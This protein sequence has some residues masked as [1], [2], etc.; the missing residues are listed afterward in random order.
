MTLPLTRSLSASVAAAGRELLIT[1]EKLSASY[2]IESRQGKA[3]PLHASSTFASWLTRSSSSAAAHTP[4]LAASPAAGTPTTSPSG[5]P[6]RL[7]D[8]LAVLFSRRWD[9]LVGARL[10]T[11]VRPVYIE[12]AEAHRAAAAEARAR[13]LAVAVCGG[14]L[15]A[16]KR[17]PRLR[18]HVSPELPSCHPSC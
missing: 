8:V 7:L 1:A 18:Q 12:D 16:N 2:V 14:R 13:A 9:D 5:V 3:S 11:A 6:P 4:S 17:F 15:E 10:H